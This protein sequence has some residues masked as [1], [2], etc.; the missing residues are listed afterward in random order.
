VTFLVVVTV[1]VNSIFV[2]INTDFHIKINV[3]VT[4]IAFVASALSA[5]P[6]VV[7]TYSVNEETLA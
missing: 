1:V 5:R 6:T 4:L 2:I 3:L 7:C